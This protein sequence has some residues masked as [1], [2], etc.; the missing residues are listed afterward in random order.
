MGNTSHNAQAG[1]QHHGEY[2]F[3][4]LNTYLK[5]YAILLVFTVITVVIAQFHFGV[6]NTLIAMAIATVK[7]WYVLTYFMG[8]R[9]ETALNRVTIGSSL[10]FALLL[11][12]FTAMDLFS[13]ETFT[14]Y[15]DVL[16]PAPNTSV[17]E[18]GKTVPKP[19]EANQE[20]AE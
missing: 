8:M 11:F 5:V 10:F 20:S 12:G 2:H 15:N 14:R 7:V 19:S 3:T 1:Q 13:R 17:T 18:D 16:N 6:F 4:P 9:Y